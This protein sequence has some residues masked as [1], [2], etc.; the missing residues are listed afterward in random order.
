MVT[1]IRIKLFHV[2]SE[3]AKKCKKERKIKL[4]KLPR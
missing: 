4:F 2:K 1:F 3:E